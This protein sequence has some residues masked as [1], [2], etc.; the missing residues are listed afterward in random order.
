MGLFYAFAAIQQN[1]SMEVEQDF[2]DRQADFNELCSPAEYFEHGTEICNEWILIEDKDA[3]DRVNSMYDLACRFYELDFGDG[4]QTS[5]F[6]VAPVNSLG[7]LKQFLHD[8]RH[9]SLLETMKRE[10]EKYRRSSGVTQQIVNAN[11]LAATFL[12]FFGLSA[13]SMGIQFTTPMTGTYDNA[14]FKIGEGVEFKALEWLLGA[15]LFQARELGL[16]DEKPKR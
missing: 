4:G 12:E 13:S 7:A 5:K 6:R 10:V 14:R 15:F 16:V 2:V 3:P 8:P 1:K 11:D 9:R